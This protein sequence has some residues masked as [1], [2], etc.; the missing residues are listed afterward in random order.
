[1]ILKK[2]KER[3]IELDELRKVCGFFTSDT[4][5]PEGCL[6]PNK[7][8]VPGCC[9][10]KDC[11]LAWDATLD[12]FKQYCPALY[13]KYQKECYGADDCGGGFIIQWRELKRG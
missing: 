13:D 4:D 7:K 8:N 12:D 10:L 1:M 11:P 2:I 9:F 5:E 3:L 6:F